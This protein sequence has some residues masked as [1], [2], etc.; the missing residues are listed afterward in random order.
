MNWYPNRL[1]T[2][3]PILVGLGPS[4]EPPGG[5]FGGRY[6]HSGY[7][8]GRP[9]RRGEGGGDHRDEDDQS[10]VTFVAG[11][12]APEGKRAGHAAPIAAGTAENKIAA[13]HRAGVGT[14][15]ALEEPVRLARRILQ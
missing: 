5:V 15:D 8:G 4:D 2:C 7:S 10:V 3:I 1:M 14:V 9:R 11:R 13:L 12:T 6:H